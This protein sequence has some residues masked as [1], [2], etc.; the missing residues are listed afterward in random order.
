VARSRARSAARGQAFLR[1]LLAALDAMP[2]KRLT[3][4]ELQADGDFCSLGVVGQARG[5]DLSKIDTENW[6]QLSRE[7]GIS[8][9][10]AREIMWENDESVDDEDWVDIEIHGPVRPHWPDYG[11][12]TRSVRVHRGDGPHRRWAYMRKWVSSQIKTQGAA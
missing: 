3:T 9:A 6:E 2:D 8:E 12:H 5:L 7:F 1:E 4:G 10:M 11:S